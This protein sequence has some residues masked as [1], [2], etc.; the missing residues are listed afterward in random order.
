MNRIDTTAIVNENVQ[1]GSNNVILPYT[2]IHGPTTIGNNNI[3]GPHVVIGSPGQDTR[4]PRYDSSDCKIEI[5]NNNII[6]EF[7]AI[8]KPCYENITKLGSDIYI[9][10]SVHIPHDAILEDNVV[11]TPMCVLAGLTKIKKGANIG[12]GATISQR[13][14]VGQYSIVAMGSAVLKNIK[15]FSRYIPNKPISVN[16][17]A[18]KKFGFEKY[19]DEITDY[20]LNNEIPKSKIL[21]DIISEFDKQHKS[22]KIKLYDV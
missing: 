4:E 13:C 12:M 7:T 2:I 14:V 9:M 20:V 21:L 5:G 18:I 19:V 11:V 22:S 16:I 15:P 1:M 8:Q 17:Y 10:Q 3:I 6:R